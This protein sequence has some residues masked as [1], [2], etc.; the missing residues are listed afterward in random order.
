M[1]QVSLALVG[2]GAR[3]SRYTTCATEGGRARLAAVA[4]PDPRRRASMLAEHPG[5]LGFEDW[6]ELAARPRVADAVIIATMDADHVEPAV[7]FAELGYHIL[8]EKPMAVRLEDCRRII[9]AAQK[10][11]VVFAVCHVMRYT[12]YTRAVKAVL[13]SGRIGEI[14]SIEHL[15]PVGWWHHAHSYV[16]GNWRRTDEA[17]FMLLAKSCHDLDWL[18][19]MIGQR[20]TRV[21]SFGGLKHFTAA[22]RPDAAAD[23]C[24]D[25]TLVSSCPYAAQRIYLP[26]VGGAESWPLNVLTSDPT[27][28]GVLHA[29]REGPYG[30]CV[31][32][33]DND[34]VDHQVVNLEFE[35]GATASFTMTAFSPK[36]PRKTRIF[37]TRGSIDGDGALL[38][39]TDFVTGATEVIDAHVPKDGHSGGD[40]GLITAFLDAVGGADPA[41]I[42]SNPKESLHSH[43]IAWA[44]E[45]ARLTGTVVTIPSKEQP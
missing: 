9:E 35:G 12:P 45:E 11:G 16:R 30:R 32:A 43:E 40:E 8:L 15:E 14:V 38:T 2:A 18:T 25:C 21:S 33:C 23:R 20:V 17:T 1:Q 24:L 6:R 34:V 41:A 39:V 29:L 28:E 10:S 5:A 42:R 36:A 31:Y 44:A 7:R 37:G 27:E 13:D 19:Y 4:E 3:G 22:N 26:Y